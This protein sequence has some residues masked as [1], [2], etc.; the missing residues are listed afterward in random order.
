MKMDSAQRGREIGPRT[1]QGP[2][3]A[4]ESRLMLVSR[5]PLTP[6][7]GIHNLYAS[8]SLSGYHLIPATG[9]TALEDPRRPWVLAIPYPQSSGQDI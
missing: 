9:S 7:Y 4:G 5:G 2:G 8:D 3:K 1:E 6:F